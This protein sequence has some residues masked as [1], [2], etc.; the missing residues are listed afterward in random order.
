MTERE[1]FKKYDNLSRNEMKSK[2]NKEVYV[3]NDV[4]TNVIV[5]GRGEKQR[6]KKKKKDEFRRKLWFREFDIMVLRE[7]FRQKFLNIIQL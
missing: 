7:Y 6:A 2:N 5:H 3:R 4:I 1:V